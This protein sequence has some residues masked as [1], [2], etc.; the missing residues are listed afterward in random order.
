MTHNQPAEA[1]AVTDE[2]YADSKAAGIANPTFLSLANFRV[3]SLARTGAP[4]GQ[5]A[6]VYTD[7]V[8]SM[9]AV[10]GRETSIKMYPELAAA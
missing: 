5:I 7:L 1:K 10:S 2:C 9:E 6:N 8:E 3:I 4:A